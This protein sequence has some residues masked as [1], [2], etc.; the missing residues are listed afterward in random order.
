MKDVRV[1]AV[2]KFTQSICIEGNVVYG[3]PR[4]CNSDEHQDMVV[5]VFQGHNTFPPNQYA[6]DY[7]VTRIPVSCGIK[8][9]WFDSSWELNPSLLWESS[10]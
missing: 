4:L 3:L 10:S 6:K 2:C 7:V 8:K 9:S 1:A 5:V